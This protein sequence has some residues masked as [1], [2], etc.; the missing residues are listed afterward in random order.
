MPRN[1]PVSAV[2]LSAD[3]SKGSNCP[4]LTLRNH[5]DDYHKFG[6]TPGKERRANKG[7]VIFHVDIKSRGKGWGW[8][9]RSS[10]TLP[11]CM[12]CMVR[13]NDGGP[14]ELQLLP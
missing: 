13:K 2:K 1:T 8:S 6:I 3:S 5:L 4:S 14:S 7:F 12:L 11:V 10:Q 9:V